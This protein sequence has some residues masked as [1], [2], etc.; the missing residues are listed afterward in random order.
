MD[1]LTRRISYDFGGEVGRAQFV[2]RCR[3]GRFVKPDA[4]GRLAA[5]PSRA[6][7][8]PIIEPAEPNAT[9]TRCGRVAMAFE[10]F[11]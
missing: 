5:R 3:C 6:D 1:E 8:F 2:P 9:C 4:E 10:G 11:F 7:A